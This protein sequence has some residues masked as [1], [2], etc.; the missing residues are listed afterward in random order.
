MPD[1]SFAILYVADPA[2]SAAFYEAALGRPRVEASATFAMIPAGPGLM[3]GLW[4]R[5][6]VVPPADA[7]D[8]RRDG[9]HRR[10]RARR[11][12]RRLCRRFA[13]HQQ[14]RL[15]ARLPCLVQQ[16]RARDGAECQRIDGGSG[17]GGLIGAG[18][19][20]AGAV[21]EIRTPDR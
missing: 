3:L 15:R 20:A 21:S 10:D 18:D 12:A 4:R 2:A 17:G 16:Q 5:N 8:R 11:A 13:R 14:H 7:G 6:G 9:Q 1:L 19:E